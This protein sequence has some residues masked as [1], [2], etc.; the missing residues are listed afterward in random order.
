MRQFKFNMDETRRLE[1]LKPYLREDMILGRRGGKYDAMYFKGLDVTAL[2]TLVHEKFA[3]PDDTQNS[4]PCIKEF[5]EFMKKYPFMKAHGYIITPDRDD[6]RVSIEGVEGS[7][8]EIPTSKTPEDVLKFNE[9]FTA[10]FRH[11]DE[12][13]IGKGHFYCWYD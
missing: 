9:D 11:A 5:L 2:Q 10:M 7:Y 3:C 4:A 13:E 8:K 1:I 6:Y 12:F